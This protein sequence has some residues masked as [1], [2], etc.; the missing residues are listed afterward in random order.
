MESGRAGT[1]AGNSVS[2]RAINIGL[3]T[4]SGPQN[5]HSRLWETSFRGL[6]ERQK[7]LPMVDNVVA[8]GEQQRWE[9]MNTRRGRH[10]FATSQGPGVHKYGPVRNKFGTIMQETDGRLGVGVRMVVGTSVNCR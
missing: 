4:L 2:S 9:L 1:G 6:G 3:G 10:T 8:I 5:A 7:T